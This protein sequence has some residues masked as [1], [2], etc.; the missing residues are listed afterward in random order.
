[1]RS[2]FSPKAGELL[3][4]ESPVPRAERAGEV[5]LRVRRCGICGS[6]LH[7]WKGEAPPP[8]VCPGHEISGV[9]AGLGPG[10]SRLREGDRVVVEGIRACGRCKPCRSG[11]PQVCTRLQLLGLTAPGGF[12]DYLVT[13][14][15]HVYPITDA[16]DD[17][18]A[19]LAEPLAVCVHA[20]RVA[21]FAH[22][23]RVL[24]LGAGT[25]GLLAVTAA[26]AAGAGEIVVS[27]RR[28]HQHATARALGADRTIDSS[29]LRSV[30]SGGGE[31]SFD[32]V[33]DT[34]AD[35]AGSLDDALAAVLPGGTVMVLGV[36]TCRPQFDALRLM[37]YEIRL[38]G[39][40]CYGRAGGRPDFEIA[41]DILSREG[42]LLREQLVTD[43]VTLDD[44]AEGFRIAADKRT[45]S[46]K[47][48]VAIS[49]QDGPDRA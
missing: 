18:S 1:M 32:V 42:A 26:R 14:A 33:L 22:D 17:E 4:R 45:G 31:P 36:F 40:M 30:M 7:W 43:R 3:V 38:I 28:P 5:L 37:M 8:Q 6:D 27:A 19:Q 44:L 24:V 49:D 16:I 13:D 46:I 11:R 34:V 39:S 15:R 35:P 41:L 12:A 10:E 20:L 21:D 9:I 47:V 25:I 23:Q 48:S 29:E 2:A